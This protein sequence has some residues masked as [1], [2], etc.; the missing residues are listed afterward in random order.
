MQLKV[1]ERIFADQA[2]TGLSRNFIIHDE[3]D[4]RVRAVKVCA[5]NYR[6]RDGNIA[7][8]APQKVERE[9]T[10]DLKLTPSSRES[11][12]MLPVRFTDSKETLERV[13]LVKLLDGI[14]AG[15]KSL[16]MATKLS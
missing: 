2:R 16:E 14:S 1:A 8:E 13:A 10:A 6:P 7:Q 4:V 11:L 15:R 5:V 12:K 9:R 3:R